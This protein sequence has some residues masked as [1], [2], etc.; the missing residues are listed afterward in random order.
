[1]NFDEKIRI[2]L[3]LVSVALPALV[4]LAAAHGLVVGPL[5]P[6]GGTGH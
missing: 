1:M 6:I 3:V 4:A 2:G 5:D